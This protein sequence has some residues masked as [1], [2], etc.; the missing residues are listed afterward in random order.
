MSATVIL[1]GDQV[2]MEELI[3]GNARLTVQVWAARQHRQE[4]EAVLVQLKAEYESLSS[5]VEQAETAW[6]KRHG[7]REAP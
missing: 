2:C 3:R 7:R 4:L 5:R 1:N 6:N